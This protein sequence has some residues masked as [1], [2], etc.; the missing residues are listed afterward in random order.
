MRSTY[1][2][3]III[4]IAVVVLLLA[5]L[6]YGAWRSRRDRQRIQE[7]IHEISMLRESPEKVTEPVEAHAK[8]VSEEKS[9]EDE[10]PEADRQFLLHLIEVV[11]ASLPTGHYGVEET[12]SRMNMSVQTFRRRLLAVTGESPK[13]FISAIQME[14]AAKLLKDNP[15]MT[16]SQIANRCGYDEATSFGRTFRKAYGISPSQYREKA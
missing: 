7:L 1:H 13:A 16:I 14:L 11:N 9:E 8:P 6:A 4:G 2:L 15:D 3:Y 5:L 12:A 10:T